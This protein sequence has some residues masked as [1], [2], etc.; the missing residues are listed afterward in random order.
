LPISQHSTEPRFALKVFDS[1]NY[2]VYL[3]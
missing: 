2:R 3:P 1:H